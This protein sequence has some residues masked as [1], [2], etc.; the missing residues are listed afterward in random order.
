MLKLFI[1]KLILAFH[2]A[3]YLAWSLSFAQLTEETNK[4]SKGNYFIENI[5]K[6]EKHL[7]YITHDQRLTNSN[8]CD[9]ATSLAST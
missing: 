7:I 9:I 3:V 5:N 2:I 8:R 6:D 4:I 1:I